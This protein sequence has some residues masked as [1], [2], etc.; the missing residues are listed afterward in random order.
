MLRTAGH[1]GSIL[2]QVARLH[3]QSITHGFLSS[4]GE[5][6][7]VLL[8]EAISRDARSILIVDIHDGDV[9]G[10]VAGGQGLRPL[11]GRLFGQAPKLAWAL[12]P[13]MISPRRLWQIVETLAYVWRFKPV[14]DCPAAELLSIAV[15][16]SV[17]GQGIAPRL[18]GALCS[19]FSRKEVSEF[20]IVVGEGL[21][22]AHRFYKKMGAH[23]MGRLEVH[24]GRFSVVYRQRCPLPEMEGGE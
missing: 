21:V 23:A 4:L 17:R 19:E 9:L 24:K 18:Y 6:F 20:C 7:L 8:Y 12:L 10:F 11:L 1:D 15:A 13:V 16:Q 2:R 14:P 5:S 3:A 22:P